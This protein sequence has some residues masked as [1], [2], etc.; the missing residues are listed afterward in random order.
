[1]IQDCT[2]AQSSLRMGQ[3]PSPAAD[4]SKDVRLINALAPALVTHRNEN[5]MFVFKLKMIVIV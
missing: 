2:H 5:Q 3:I 4:F 1:M